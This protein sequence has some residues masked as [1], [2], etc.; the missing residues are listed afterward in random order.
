MYFKILPITADSW[1]SFYHPAE[2]RR[3]SRS[4]WLV[5]YPNGLPAH[6][7]SPIQVVTGPVSINYVDR[8]QRHA[9]HSAV[10]LNLFD[11]YPVRSAITADCSTQQ[12][13]GT[14]SSRPLSV[15]ELTYCLNALSVMVTVLQTNRHLK[16]YVRQQMINSLIKLFSIP[17]IH[18]TPCCHRLLQ[19]PNLRRRTHAHS[20]P[21]HDAHLCDCNFLTIGC[22]T[23]TV[24]KF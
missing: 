8:S 11:C 15:S 9:D 24:I 22:C 7:L 1:Y 13:H 18:C 19:R 14:D 10:I 16:N 20:L 23:K 3:L 5:T 2:R 6:Q 12:V 17:V 4:R 21:Q